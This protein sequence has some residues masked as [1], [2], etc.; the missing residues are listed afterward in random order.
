MNRKLAFA[1]ITAAF[2]SGN[3]LADDITMDPNPFVS[4][5]TRA[6]VQADLA[7]FKQSGVNPWSTTYD[8]LKNFRSARSRAEVIADYVQAR[9]SVAAMNSEDSGSTYLSHRAEPSLQLASH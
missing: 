9:D 7:Q 6:E 1:A 5:R 3:V 8:P 2:V 4:Q